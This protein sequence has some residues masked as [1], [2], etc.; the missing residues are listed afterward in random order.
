MPI[1]TYTPLANITLGSSAANVTFSSISGSYRDLIL[2]GQGLSS[3]ASGINI[4]FNSDTGSNYNQIVMYGDGSSVAS[5][6]SSSQTSFQVGRFDN[7]TLAN[8]TAN[9]MDYSATDKHKTSLHRYNSSGVLTAARTSRWAATS[10]ITS[11]VL[12]LDS[13]TFNSGCT[14]ALYGIVS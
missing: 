5:S 14:F 3:T 6:S 9:F 11:F 12:Y 4:R 10:A 13:G 1:P 8:F 7:S 2:V